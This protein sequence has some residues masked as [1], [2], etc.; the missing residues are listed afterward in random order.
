MQ[1]II[2]TKWI[3]IQK[4]NEYAGRHATHSFHFQTKNEFSDE[5]KTWTRRTTLWGGN[6]LK[7]RVRLV[8]N[9]NKDVLI[10]IND[11]FSHAL[12]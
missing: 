1:K 4:I 8:D 5:T 6:L 10:H 2:A 11:I 3:G 7:K 12:A 9:L